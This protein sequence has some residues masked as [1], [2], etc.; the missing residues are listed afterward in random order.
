M[1][2]ADGKKKVIS[3]QARIKAKGNPVT[4]TLGAVAN[5]DKWLNYVNKNEEGLTADELKVKQDEIE[6]YRTKLQ[7]LV[8]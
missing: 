2:G 1:E 3:V 8:N 5:P 4:I 7:N 6:E